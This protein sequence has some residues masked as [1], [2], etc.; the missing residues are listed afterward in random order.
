M[1][2]SSR[3]H[4][5]AGT[6]PTSQPHPHDLQEGPGSQSLRYQY[7]VPDQVE[8]SDAGGF[9]LLFV[10]PDGKGVAVRGQGDVW[11]T[12]PAVWSESHRND[13]I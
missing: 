8:R 9:L 12:A 5:C 1:Q 6:P 3:P 2:S 10:E 7:G 13:G 11:R 4:A